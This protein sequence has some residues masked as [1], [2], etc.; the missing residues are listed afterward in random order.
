MWAVTTTDYTSALLGVPSLGGYLYGTIG[1]NPLPPAILVFATARD[2][3]AAAEGMAKAA[4]NPR[5]SE[6]LRAFIAELAPKVRD[7]EVEIALGHMFDPA[8]M[9]RLK[10]VMAELQTLVPGKR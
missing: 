10:D 4:Q 5:F 3:K 1:A 6:K 2:A 9:E 7:R 8:R